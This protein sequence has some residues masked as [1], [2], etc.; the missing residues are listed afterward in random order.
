VIEVTESRNI[1]VSSMVNDAE[2]AATGCSTFINPAIGTSKPAAQLADGRRWR[3]LLTL[4]SR[5]RFSRARSSFLKV[6][7]S[8]SDHD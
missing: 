5:R 1:S 6:G 3:E 2:R 4:R 7:A 8:Y